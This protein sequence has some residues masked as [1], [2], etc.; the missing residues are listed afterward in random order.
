VATPAA[1]SSAT[2]SAIDPNLKTPTTHQWSV[3]I[4]REIAK[5][6]IVDVA[7]IG[8]RAY[9]LLGAYNVNQTRIFTKPLSGCVQFNVVKGGGDSAPMDNLLKGD[10][11]LDS[12]LLKRIPISELFKLEIRADATNLTNPVMFG[13]P[14]TDITSTTFGRIRNTVTSRSR[15][16]RLGA[17]IHF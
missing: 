2:K 11:R 14:T 17:Q 8:R 15:K 10:T 1:F 6:T 9:H 3:D 12:S 13:N 4:Q 5:N 7:Y 16:I